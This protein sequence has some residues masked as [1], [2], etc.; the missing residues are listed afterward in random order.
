[1]PPVGGE[2]GGLLRAQPW[3]EAPRQGAAFLMTMLPTAGGQ[4]S[5]EAT[6]VRRLPQ[7]A[8][9]GQPEADQDEAGKAGPDEAGRAGRVVHRPFE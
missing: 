7:P 3:F 4:P 1:M 6:S 2:Q 5:I 8:L 9:I